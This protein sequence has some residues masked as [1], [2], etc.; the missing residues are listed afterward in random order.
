MKQ[1]IHKSIVTDHTPIYWEVN[2]SDEL[3]IVHKNRAIAF[4]PR[5]HP[6]ALANALAN[7]YFI[8]RAV[9]NHDRLLA[10]LKDCVDLLKRN[11]FGDL[12]SVREAKDAIKNAEK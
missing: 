1:E 11:G 3:A 5:Q 12:A 7:A 9:N 10:A 6:Y 4:I 2:G 8:V